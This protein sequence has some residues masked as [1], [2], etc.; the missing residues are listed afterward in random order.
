MFTDML[1]PFSDMS[2]SFEIND[3]EDKR[4]PA[5]HHTSMP[6]NAGEFILTK[7]DME[8]KDWY[9]AEVSEVLPDRIKVNYYTTVTPPLEDFADKSLALRTRHL[10][11]TSFLRTW[12]LKTG[13][14]TATT[15]P[16]TGIRLTRDVY[17][18]KI[19]LNETD[20][21]ALVRNVRL[22]ALGVLD[23]ASTK[24][25][26][27]LPIPHHAGAGGEDDFQ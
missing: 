15:Q 24:L 27:A 4:K 14:R 2:D 12:C 26:A 23:A 5:L 25:A 3:N 7:D 6:F 11:D 19:P 13:D 8:A 21:H 20:R 10:N 17:S 16:P 22:T 18:G 9:C 1:V